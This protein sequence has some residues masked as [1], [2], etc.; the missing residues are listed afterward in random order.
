MFPLNETL[1]VHNP[2]EALRNQEGVFEVTSP[3]GDHF[4]VICQPGHQHNVKP[5]AY[6]AEDIRSDFKW[7]IKKLGSEISA[8]KTAA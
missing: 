2:L 8:G 5:L 6:V 1:I 3:T 7:A 4:Q